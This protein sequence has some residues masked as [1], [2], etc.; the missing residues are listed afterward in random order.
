MWTG[1]VH[2]NLDEKQWKFVQEQ[3]FESEV[4]IKNKNYPIALDPEKTLSILQKLDKE[5]PHQT[6]SDTLIALHKQVKALI[7]A[8]DLSEE[9]CSARFFDE[10][11]DLFKEHANQTLNVIPYL[12]YNRRKHFFVCVD[13]YKLII[14]YDF[15]HLKPNDLLEMNLLRREIENSLGRKLEL[16]YFKIPAKVLQESMLETM[17]KLNVFSDKK[18]INWQ[19]LDSPGRKKTLDKHFDDSI[20]KLCRSINN[21]FYTTWEIFEPHKRDK[22]IIDLLDRWT[23][24]WLINVSVC[25]DILNQVLGLYS[26]DNNSMQISKGDSTNLKKRNRLTEFVPHFWR[27]N[28]S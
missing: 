5:F 20:G 25:R 26:E 2:A 8:S 7:Q 27:F 11:N 12:A 4:D 14:N 19:S 23:K 10:T 28:R 22:E 13:K 17:K 3:L 6:E 16:P 24:D 18:L 15:D 1:L 21:Q 9:N